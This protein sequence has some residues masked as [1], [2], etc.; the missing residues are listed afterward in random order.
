MLAGSVSVGLQIPGAA[1]RVRRP[2]SLAE[3]ADFLAQAASEG[4]IVAGATALQLEWRRGEPQPAQL[5]DITGLAELAGISAT[6]GH[7][8]I[9]AATR[10]AEL[11]E[12]RLVAEQ[13]PLLAETLGRVAAPGIRRLA[14]LGV[15]AARRPILQCVAL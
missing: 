11:E 13:V 2:R 15:K 7:I 9:G 1:L 5:I 4:R 3:A 6:A 10:L 12:S 14:T 8:R